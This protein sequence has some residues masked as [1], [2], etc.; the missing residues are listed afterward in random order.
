MLALIS[1]GAQVLHRDVG[2]FARSDPEVVV[3]I[4]ADIEELIK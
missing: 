1:A 4:A 2:E 3:T